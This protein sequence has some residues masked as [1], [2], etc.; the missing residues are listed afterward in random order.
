MV[1]P[2]PHARITR[3]AGSHVEALCLEDDGQK[4][5]LTAGVTDLDTSLTDVDR[6]DFTH[7]FRLAKPELQGCFL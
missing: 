7:F 1:S 3:R 5:E 6:D 2:T 4:T